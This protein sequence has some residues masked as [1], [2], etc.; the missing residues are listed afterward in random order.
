MKR[1]DFIN[2]VGLGLIASSLPVAIAACPCHRAEYASD[3]QVQKGP[4]EKP[5]KTYTAK[6]EGDSVLVKS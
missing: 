6:I 1:R 2:W 4:A 3:G 5:L